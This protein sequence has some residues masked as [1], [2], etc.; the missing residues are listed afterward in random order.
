MLAPQGQYDPVPMPG[1]DRRIPLVGLPFPAAELPTLLRAVEAILLTHTH[2]DHWDALAQELLD[3][4]LP[5]LCPPA[6]AG[7][8]RE[9]GFTQVQP[10]EAEL[11]WAG[12]HFSRTSGQHGT[13]EVGAMMGTV[14]GF[15]VAAQHQRL[16]LAG[17]TIWCADVEPAL[18]RYRPTRVVVNAGGTRLAMGDPITMTAADVMQTARHAPQATV[19]A[20]HL[21]AVSHA[22]ESRALVRTLAEQE[23]LAARVIA[24]NDGDWVTLPPPA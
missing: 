5:L 4:D 10:I 18:A 1:N 11:D 16:Y 22:P 20:V 24:P 21:E 2:P 19:Y 8:L 3:K 6:N 15:V 23:G 14:S 12:I 9:Q 7:L 13:G 17:D